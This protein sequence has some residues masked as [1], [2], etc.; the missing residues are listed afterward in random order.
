MWLT[1]ILIFLII[2]QLPLSIWALRWWL[3]IRRTLKNK[4][5]HWNK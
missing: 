1:I 2:V 3:E 4:T 5:K